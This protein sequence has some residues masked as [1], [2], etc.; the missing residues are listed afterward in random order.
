MNTQAAIVTLHVLGATV[1]TGGHLV[2]TLGVLP[3]ALRAKDPGMIRDY[4]ARFEK[5]GIHALVLQVLTGAHLAATQLQGAWLDTENPLARHVMAKIVLLLLTIGLAI[6][7]RLLLVPRLTAENMGAL[8]WHI[9]IVTLLA[10]LFVV[11][12]VGI[13]TGGVI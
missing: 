8:A 7:A 12:G 3:R 1:W 11:L 4:E 2:L 10:V 5:L 6:H 13:R 9:R